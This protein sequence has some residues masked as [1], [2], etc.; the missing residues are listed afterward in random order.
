LSGVGLK[1][2]MITSAWCS[3]PPTTRATYVWPD[4]MQKNNNNNKQT[5][6]QNKKQS[7]HENIVKSGKSGRLG[8][9]TDK[10]IKNRPF[11]DCNSNFKKHT[12][13]KSDHRRK[14]ICLNCRNVF[15][16]YCAKKAPSCEKRVKLP[17]FN[18]SRRL[19]G[20]VVGK[21]LLLKNEYPQCIIR[22]KRAK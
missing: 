21:F 9:I 18:F 16:K 11:W 13:H 5:N 8:P 1:T 15:F 2:T 22:I 12:K 4:S 19:C 7:K 14:Q 17:F 10:V 6:K 3:T 20:L